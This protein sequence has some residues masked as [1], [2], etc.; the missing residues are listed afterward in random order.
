M[1]NPLLTTGL[2]LAL[3]VSHI[4]CAGQFEDGRAAYLRGDFAAAV[5][6]WRPLAEKGDPVAQYSMGVTYDKGQGVP[7]DYRQA[8]AWYRKAADQGHSTAQYNL[9]VMYSLGQGVLQ[10][11]Q[12]AVAWYRKA[13]VQGNAFAQSSLASSYA[14][15]EGIPQNNVRAHMWWNISASLFS[16]EDGKSAARN[17]DLIAAKLTPEQIA[18][19]Q[20][21][22]RVCLASSYRKCD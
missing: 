4:A 12:Q 21:L 10:D 2:I 13:A 14:K 17:R 6:L 15:G 19:A 9:G 3:F 18:Q 8:V 1:R 22:A 7:Q 20:E 16:V 5:A 11:Y